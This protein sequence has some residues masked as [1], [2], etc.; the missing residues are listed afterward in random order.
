VSVTSRILYSTGCSGKATGNVGA[1]VSLEFT[2]NYQVKA[3]P[4]DTALE[5]LEYFRGNGPWIGSPF[6][7]SSA[8]TT[9]AI[10]TDVDAQP[11]QNSGGMFFVTAKFSSPSG[12]DDENNN[13]KKDKDG[14]KTDD[15]LQWHDEI[16]V[17][18][19]QVSCPIEYATY[20]G[21]N[22]A[23]EFLRPGL[24]ARD[25]CNSAGVPFDPLPEYELDITVLRITKYTASWDDALIAPY[26]GTINS[27]QFVINKPDYNFSMTVPII[28]GKIKQWSGNFH[29]QD[30]KKYWKQTIELHINPL[31]W[32]FPL[33]DRGTT[34]TVVDDNP[35]NATYGFKIP[36]RLVDASNIPLTEPQKLDG[37]GNLLR[38]GRDPVYLLYGKYTEVPYANINW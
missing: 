26:R 21:P 7:Y 3:A 23:N 4:T 17:S 8:F 20:L 30:K 38:A 5:V 19:T 31:G 35:A 25:P 1:P 27:D 16:D 11:I 2:A 13:D 24:I 6:Q 33:L 28:Q 10:C 37:N 32:R 22:P 34:K 15:P 12:G 9:D 18:T 14:N 36:K 29:F